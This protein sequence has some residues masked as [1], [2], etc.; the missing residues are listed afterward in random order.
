M[1]F[2][3]IAFSIII[4]NIGPVGLV[5]A[6]D[7]APMTVQIANPDKSDAAIVFKELINLCSDPC[8]SVRRWAADSLGEVGSKEIDN[9]SRPEASNNALARIKLLEEDGVQALNNLLGDCVPIVQVSAAKAL[10]LIGPRGPNVDYTIHNLVMLLQDKNWNVRSTATESLGKMGSATVKFVPEIKNLLAHPYWDV[11]RQAADVLGRIGPA[12]K[13]AIPELTGLLGDCEPL[14]RISAANALFTVFPNRIDALPYFVNLL[15]DPHPGVRSLAAN[16]I[17]AYGPEARDAVPALINLLG[18]NEPTARVAAAI[19][20]GQI[21]KDAES[22]DAA[23]I[24][25]LHC[26]NW[27]DRQAALDALVKITQ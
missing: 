15:Q 1:R 20:L 6:A 24:G 13:E 17:G 11:R 22:A 7:R 26:G 5:F 23:L 8:W 9:S 12:A 10:G 25:L 14:V 27:N 19:A 21:G 4:L 3:T 2:L 16:L 18:D